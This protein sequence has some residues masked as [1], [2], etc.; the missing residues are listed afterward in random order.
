MSKQEEKGKC[1]LMGQ[2]ESRTQVRVTL[3]GFLYFNPKLNLPV[4]GYVGLKGKDLTDLHRAPKQP[5][6][7]TH[8]C[9]TCTKSFF[10]TL[11]IHDNRTELFS[12][13]TL[14]V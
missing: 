11:K 10:P 6:Y 5:A 7:Q 3:V 12:P 9:K 2:W 13:F 14:S 1:P 4:L 8:Y